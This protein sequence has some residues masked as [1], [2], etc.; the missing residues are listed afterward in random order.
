MDF[1]TKPLTLLMFDHVLG[2]C[3]SFIEASVARA[4]KTCPNRKILGASS[5]SMRCV[6]AT[7]ISVWFE[8]PSQVHRQN[9]PV[10]THAATDTVA[11]G[12]GME[13][14]DFAPLSP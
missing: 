7:K 3:S 9:T 11:R 14:R 6:N 4:A 1:T 8:L 5:S 12:T 13:V 2:W 10:Y